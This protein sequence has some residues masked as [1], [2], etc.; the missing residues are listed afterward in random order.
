M[1]SLVVFSKVDVVLVGLLAP[2]ADVWLLTRV[3]AHVGRQILFLAELLAACVALEILLAVVDIS[4]VALHVLLRGERLGT[5][6]DR[7]DPSIC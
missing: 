1:L 5:V 3:H 6:G 4:D 2:I 7:T